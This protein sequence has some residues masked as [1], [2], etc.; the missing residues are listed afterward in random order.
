MILVCSTNDHKH[1]QNLRGNCS[2]VSR[3]IVI[4]RV[5]DISN[6][7][8][9]FNF[10]ASDSKKKHNP[11]TPNSRQYNL[12][13]NR[14]LQPRWHR[15]SS[16]N[17]RI[18]SNTA[19]K[20]LTSAF[21]QLLLVSLQP[22]SLCQRYW[23]LHVISRFLFYSWGVISWNKMQ[24][25]HNLYQIASWQNI[26]TSKISNWF[27]NYFLYLIKIPS[28]LGF[29]LLAIYNTSKFMPLNKTGSIFESD[30]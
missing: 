10:M 29:L 1:S 16:Q 18:I 5:C 9:A 25:D 26:P 7:R 4:V 28:I 21:V 15:L 13:T 3:C 14:Q 6:D 17:L 19:V 20:E 30:L 27:L 23:K 12:S 24:K 8:V 11:L 22:Q 2:G